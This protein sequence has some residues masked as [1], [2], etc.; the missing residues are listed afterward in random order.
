M[1]P[2]R[3]IVGIA[4]TLMLAM[5]ALG[6]DA[7]LYLGGEGTL[8]AD[9]PSRVT[10]RDDVRAT[11]RD[12]REELLG[13]F[14]A[15]P[16]AVDTIG[17][18]LLRLILVTGAEGMDRCATVTAEMYRVSAIDERTVLGRGS[19]PASLAPRRETVGFTDVPVTVTDPGP[20]A[21]DLGVAILLGNTC[22]S[23]RSVVLLYDAPAQP[24]QVWLYAAADPP[25]TTT[26][27]TTM[28]VTSLTAT[29][30]TTT[31]IPSTTASSST[32]TTLAG[33]AAVSPGFAALECELQ[34]VGVLL[35]ETPANALGGARLAQRL[36]GH[37]LRA[38]Q[39]IGEARAGRRIGRH[40]LAANRRLG[41]IR[42]IVERGTVGGRIAM[43]VSVELLDA[44][45]GASGQ[46]GHLRTLR[47]STERRREP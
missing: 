16:P 14:L 13:S 46:I 2:R 22:G 31:S 19:A 40:L 21:G 10:P 6:Q 9:A 5:P 35:A 7:V 18:A 37:L 15:S 26:T 47:A 39:R 23:L 12:G 42:R 43:P 25:S 4:A 3:T 24:S 33:C 45:A 27:V 17:S 44:V 1:R 34:R 28:T 30:T 32:T 29:S 38:T 8:L 20:E 11:L 36:D 41:S